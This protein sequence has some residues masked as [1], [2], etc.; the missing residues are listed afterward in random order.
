MTSC[1]F[2]KFMD[3][4]FS[5]ILTFPVNLM[6]DFK[7]LAEVITLEGPSGNCWL[8][9]LSQIAGHVYLKE[10][11]KEFV[12]AHHVEEG[13]CL[14]FE[15]CGSSRFSVL[16]FDRS[17]CEREAAYF[18]RIMN[19]IPTKECQ[20]EEKHERQ[21]P[22]VLKFSS[23]RFPCDDNSSLQ[24]VSD[25]EQ[26]SSFKGKI[27]RGSFSTRS[28]APNDKTNFEHDI[29]SKKVEHSAKHDSVNTQERQTTGLKLK[30]KVRYLRGTKAIRAETPYF[31]KFLLP[32]HFSGTHSFMTFPCDFAVK[33]LHLT[34]QKI[35]LRYHNKMWSAMYKLKSASNGHSVTGISGEGWRKFV[36]DN[37]LCRGDGC[38]FVLSEASKR[39]KVFDVH[40][41]RVD[42]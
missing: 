21:L 40:I 38:I 39:V 41:V 34:P 24:V 2:V 6:M 7:K 11:W 8:V 36:Q 22:D 30:A 10:G 17:G 18:V 13:D 31:T 15:Y 23:P 28:C 25:D 32:S 29:Q 20:A 4:N 3:Q 1:Q 26:S 16:I 9:R 33:H 37:E 19:P 35:F 12:E 27:D 14:V 5:Q 42:D